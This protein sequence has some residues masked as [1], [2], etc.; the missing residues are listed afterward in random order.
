MKK[1]RLDT[2][3]SVMVVWVDLILG[4]SEKLLDSRIAE[5]LT[6]CNARCS[7]VANRANEIHELR[8]SVQ[9]AQ[10]QIACRPTKKPRFQAVATWKM[11]KSNPHCPQK[12]QSMRQ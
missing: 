3:D 12:T 4:T 10:P 6:D 5:I 11:P 2:I 1:I 7:Q 9:V 8:Q